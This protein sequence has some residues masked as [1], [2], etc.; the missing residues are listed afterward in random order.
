MAKD[1]D[2]RSDKRCN[3]KISMTSKAGTRFVLTKTMSDVERA[4]KL[5]DLLSWVTHT[6]GVEPFAARSHVIVPRTA[7]A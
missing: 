3:L 4:N 5:K 2:W 6:C 1:W 7:T